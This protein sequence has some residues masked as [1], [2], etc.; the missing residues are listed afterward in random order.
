VAA[1][2]SR[3]KGAARL[4]EADSALLCG[5]HLEAGTV[6]SRNLEEDAEFYHLSASGGKDLGQHKCGR[7]LDQGTGIPPHPVEAAHY[8]ELSA[9]QGNQDAQFSF[10]ICLQ[11]IDATD[12]GNH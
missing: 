7:F 8:Y 11:K 4:G 1:G 5:L 3:F 2:L 6:C 9:Q 12:Y 10:G